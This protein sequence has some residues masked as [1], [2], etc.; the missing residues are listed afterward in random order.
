VL[1]LFA[2]V[3]LTAFMPLGLEEPLSAIAV[4]STTRFFDKKLETLPVK[5]LQLDLP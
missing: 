5:N 1:G 4:A 3:S 2:T